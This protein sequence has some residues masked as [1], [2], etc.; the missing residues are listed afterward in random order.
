MTT[1]RAFAAVALVLLASFAGAQTADDEDLKVFDAD[2]GP[3]WI[4]V[5]SYPEAQRESYA[6]FARKCSRCHTLARPINSSMRGDE[7]MAYVSRMS[8]KPG[9]GISPGDGD[10]I[11][12]F[13]VLDSELRERRAGA[14]DPELLP[15]LGV[16]QELT[17]VRRFPAS[18]QDIAAKD[19]LLR[20]E[21]EG[22]R[23]LDVSRLLEKD[24][25]QDLVR[26]T[27][28]EPNRCEI[29]IREVDTM[30]GEAPADVSAPPSG[31]ALAAAVQEAVGSEPDPE[32]RIELILDWLD[33]AVEREHRP[34]HA[35]IET[36]LQERRGDAT[37]FTH[38]FVA[39]ARTCGVPARTRVG[40]VARRT[41][42]Y[43]HS[44]ADVW[45]DGWVPVDPFLGQFPA[46]ANRIRFRSSDGD[47]IAAWDLAGVPGLERLRLRVAVPEDEASADGG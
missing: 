6:L 9:S 26:W 11:L 13:L 31:G 44:W 38:A 23:R 18:T 46:D 39:M 24:G 22:D 41:A 34:G 5:S 1:H 35:D 2:L 27:R 21:I 43:F 25:A 40:F 20:V 30:P 19:G 10:A 4:D 36:I 15:F 42:F 45:L 14:V 3:A 32:E 16:C 12:E 17:G 37:E 28:R 33:E 8:R 47:A 29:V 7:W